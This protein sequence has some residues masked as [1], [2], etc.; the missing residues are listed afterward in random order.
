MKISQIKTTH[1]NKLVNDF[2]NGETNIKKFFNWSPL[3]KED[4]EKRVQFLKT[5]QYNRSELVDALLSFH[6][7]YNAGEKAVQN[8]QKL[9]NDD[10]FVVIGGQQAGLLTG[11][12]YSIHKIISIINLAKKYEEDYG[13][14]VVPVFWIAGED[15]DLDEINHVFIQ[16][17]NQIK[18][19]TYFHRNASAHSASKTILDQN[20]LR[21][22]LTKI[23]ESYEETN[24]SNEILTLVEEIAIESETFVDFFAKLSFRLFEK[25]GLV[26]IDA[27]DEVVR[28]IESNM[29]EKMICMQKEV[30]HVL[31]TTQTKLIEQ[32]YQKSLHIAE[33]SIHLFYHANEGRLLLEADEENDLFTT[34]NKQYCFS[35]DELLQIANEKPHYLSNNV[36][37][38]PVMQEFL[39]PTLS[40][41]GG[42]GEIAYWAELK[43]VFN[44]FQMEMPPVFLRHSF[45]IIERNI[46]S[47]MSDFDVEIEAIFSPEFTQ[48]KEKWL[49]NELK[50]NYKEEI[51]AIRD[52]IKEIHVPL[53]EMV[54]ETTPN[55]RD[56]AKEN[57]R[58]IDEQLALVE[59][60]MEQTIAKQHDEQ[61]Q[62]WDRILNQ[63][64]PNNKPQER[65]WNVFY[66]LNKYGLNFVH[67]LCQLELTWDNEQQIVLL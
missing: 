31:N 41:V 59:K 43:E 21:K 36:V 19:Q 58:K 44:V 56:F 60:K 28:Q 38:R 50:I 35:K 14:S 47:A 32:G 55:L 34:K 6:K 54:A 10:T 51:Q 5:Q 18:K 17:K 7:K 27:D 53:Q 39:F 12:L 22:W 33:N 49:Q 15:H 61:I 25:E 20:E 37:T 46:L 62:K 65:V 64:C 1:S 2:I 52:Q 4:I 9:L 57:Y 40:F 30:R 63:L 67:D 24:F 23:F 29:F 13:L 66:Y 8:V 16:L 11:P 26:L 45:T 3:V 42:P 48:L